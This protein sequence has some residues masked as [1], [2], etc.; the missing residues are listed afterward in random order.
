[1]SSHLVRCP[2]VRVQLEVWIID[3]DRRWV[4]SIRPGRAAA[5]PAPASAGR[6]GRGAG[7]DRSIIKFN[8]AANMESVADLLKLK[9]PDMRCSGFQLDNWLSSPNSLTGKTEC[10]VKLF[11]IHN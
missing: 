6:R 7:V 5:Q 3:Y 11:A 9:K 10:I 4:Q 1:M 2:I 8:H